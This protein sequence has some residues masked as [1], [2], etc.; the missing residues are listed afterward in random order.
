MKPGEDEYVLFSTMTDKEVSPRLSR[1]VVV[2]EL[3][4]AR[5]IRRDEAEDVV[6]WTDKHLCSCRSR[7]GERPEIRN[8]NVVM[9]GGGALAYEF[10][11]YDE[12]QQFMSRATA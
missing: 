7:L 6:S 12:V 3:M 5:G 1:E 2:E 4:S 8:G 9:V 11:S 10:S